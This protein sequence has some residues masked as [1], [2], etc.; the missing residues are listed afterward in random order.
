[1]KRTIIAMAFSLFLLSGCFFPSAPD[2]AVN[3]YTLD[4]QPPVSPPLPACDAGIKIMRFS[5]AQEI[6]TQS[7]LFSSGPGLRQ[8]YNYS[9]W[10]IYPADLCTDYLSRDFRAAE[11]LKV[12]G[13]GL[14]RFRLEGAVYEFWRIDRPQGS[15]VR[16]A[17]SCTLLD[18]YGRENI[19]DQLLFQRN[20][21]QEVTVNDEAPI[22]MALAMSQA[23]AAFSRQVQ[24]DVYQAVRARLSQPGQ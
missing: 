17:L 8:M 15:V 19:S 7:M 21:M 14:S 23:F 3:F 13:S 16:L 4:Y 20:Y 6:N 5:A 18:Q 11:V 10:R 9:R 2:I 12:V 24:S 1:M 22:T